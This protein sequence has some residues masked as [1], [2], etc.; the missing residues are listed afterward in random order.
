[1]NISNHPVINIMV[2]FI[3]GSYFL[4]TIDCRVHHKDVYF[5]FEVLKEAAEEVGPQ[6]MVQVVKDATYLCKVMGKLV[7]VA[8]KHIWWTPSCVHA[9]HIVFKDLGKID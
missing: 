4:M 8:Y 3:K 6:N 2:I 1:M 5:K 9:M 7:E